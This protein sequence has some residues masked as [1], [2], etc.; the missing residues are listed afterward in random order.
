MEWSLGVDIGEEV[1]FRVIVALPSQDLVLIEQ[2][3]VNAYFYSALCTRFPFFL[4]PH[5]A[6]MLQTSFEYLFRFH[7]R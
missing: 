1:R 6:H 5:V 7:Y 4:L 2:F 3:V